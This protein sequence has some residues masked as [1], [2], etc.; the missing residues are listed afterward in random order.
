MN[1]LPIATRR[2]D[3]L[4]LF[5]F[6][7]RSPCLVFLG[8]SGAPTAPGAHF[9]RVLPST[10][11]CPKL[12]WSEALRACCGLNTC[13]CHPA[14]ECK[15]SAHHSLWKSCCGFTGHLPLFEFPPGSSRYLRFLTCAAVRQFC[16]LTPHLCC[17]HAV[18]LEFVSY[19]TCRPQSS[20]HWPGWVQ[21][22]ILMQ[23]LGTTVVMAP[24]LQHRQHGIWF[25]ILFL[26]SAV[27]CYGDGQLLKV[28]NCI[29]WGRCCIAS[30]VATCDAGIPYWHWFMS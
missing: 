27:L 26:L 2:G 3:S 15:L 18:S 13:K 5:L 12:A 16:F 8:K 24:L 14:T 7:S 23:S 22:P 10:A 17:T 19:S 29:P 4:L 9:W 28:K 21:S 20:P 30:K 1:L 25:Y 11:V 6:K